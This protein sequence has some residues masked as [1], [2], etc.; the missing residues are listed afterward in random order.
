MAGLLADMT[1]TRL[2]CANKVWVN[3]DFTKFSIVPLEGFR[4]WADYLA[5]DFK[6]Y[7]LNDMLSLIPDTVPVQNYDKVMNLL[8]CDNYDGNEDAKEFEAVTQ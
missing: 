6:G 8:T 5:K 3:N 1:L 7:K 4:N 2:V